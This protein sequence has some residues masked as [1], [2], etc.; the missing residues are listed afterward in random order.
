[1]KNNNVNLISKKE[2]MKLK[3]KI[4]A[5]DYIECSAETS[6]GIEDVLRATVRSALNFNLCK[7]PMRKSCSIS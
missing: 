1:M 4:K 7:S 2:A 5:I 6:I 3:E